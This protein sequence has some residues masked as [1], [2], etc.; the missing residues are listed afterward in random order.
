M[1]GD[2]MVLARQLAALDRELE[3]AQV[4][5][6]RALKIYEMIRQWRGAPV[7]L[8]PGDRVFRWDDEKKELAPLDTSPPHQSGW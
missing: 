4:R 7:P 8:R 5:L 3:P 6:D 1:D 2:L